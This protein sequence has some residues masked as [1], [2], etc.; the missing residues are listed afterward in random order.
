MQTRVLQAFLESLLT[1]VSAK[2]A[3]AKHIELQLR[4]FCFKHQNIHLL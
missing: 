2:W 3:N 1:C 4:S